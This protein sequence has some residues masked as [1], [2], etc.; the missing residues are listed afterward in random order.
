[1]VL[2]AANLPAEVQYTVHLSTLLR[3][4]PAACRQ[5]FICSS[6]SSVCRSIE[7]PWT[8]SPVS[9]SK[10]GKPETYRVSPLRVTADVGA[11][12]RS[13]QV[14]KGSTRMIFFSSLR[15]DQDRRRQMS[16]P[17]GL[18]TSGCGGA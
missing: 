3:D 12:H 6:T 1:M 16:W 17:A 7:A 8:T 18:R 4:D 5:S 13:R 9:G 2:T 11:F 14:D 15:S 10:G